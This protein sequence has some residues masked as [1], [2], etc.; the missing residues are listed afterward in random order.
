MEAYLYPNIENDEVMRMLLQIRDMYQG[1]E[2][3]EMLGKMH[4]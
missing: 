2:L 1:T 3:G 4:D